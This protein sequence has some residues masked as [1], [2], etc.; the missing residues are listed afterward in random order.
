MGPEEPKRYW[1]GPE[2][3]GQ[4]APASNDEFPQPLDPVRG[5]FGRRDFL[6]AAGFTFVAAASLAGCSRAPV[7]KAIPFLVQPEEILPG[8]SYF[9][10]STCAGCTAGC[11]TLVKTRDGRPIK[12]EGNPE[13]AFSRGGLCAVGQASLLEL[14]DSQRLQGPMKNGKPTSWEEVDRSIREQLRSIR[15]S[16]VPVRFL[17]GSITSLT[18]REHLDRFLAQFSDAQRIAY[19]SLSASAILDAHEQTHGVRALP[20][21]RFDHAEVIVGFDADFLGTWISPVEFT[22]AYC[23]GRNLEANPPR[24]SY[25]AQFESRMSLT[26]SKA[27]RRIRVS[28]GELS[29]TVESLMERIAKLGHET[30][31]PGIP[32]MPGVSSELLEELAQ[33]LWQARGHSLVVCGSQD[34]RVQVL[35]NY[36]NHLLGNY[37]A[38][39]DL[40]HPSRQREGNDRELESLLK[41]IV[42]GR[43]AALFLYGVNP[44]YDLPGGKE[45]ADALKAVPLVVSFAERIDETARHAHFVCPEPHFLESWGDAGA[46]PGVISVFQPALN[47]LGNTRTAVESI[48]TWMGES[49]PAYEI[50]RTHWEA[51]IFLRQS[52]ERTFQEFWDH[53]VERGFAEVEPDRITPKPFRVDAVQPLPSSQP[54]ASGALTLVLYPKVSMLDGRHGHNAWLQELPDPISK[55]AWDNYASLSPAAANRLGV[56][57]GDVVRLELA[58]HGNALEL[59]AHVQPG[60]HDEIIAVALGYGRAGTGRFAKAGPQWLF[61][62]SG[63]GENGLV[64]VNA[65]PMLASADGALSYAGRVV[66]ISKTGRQHPLGCTQ[67]HHSLTTP[68]NIP[69]VGGKRR[70]IVEETTFPV[71]VAKNSNAKNEAPKDKEMEELWPADHPYTGHRWAMAIDMTACTGCSACV[72]ACQAENNIPTVGRD[73]VRRQREMH[74]LRIDRYYSGTDDVDVVHQPMMCQQCDHAPCETVCPVLATVHSAEGLNQ[75]IYNRCVGTRYCANNCPYKTRR[76]NW[77][78]YGRDDRLQNLALNPDVTVRTRGIMEK[79]TFCVQRIQ[80]AKIEANRRGEPVADGAIQTAC[81]QSCPAQ[82]IVFGDWNNPK[83]RIAELGRNPRRYRVLGEFNFQPAV[84]YLSVVRNREFAKKERKNG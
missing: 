21:F 2:E 20:H 82:A 72:I 29:R 39:I 74:W 65:A 83:S 5:E 57:Q 24:F 79:C 23:A 17:T 69:L 73:E 51:K 22:A 34:V 59:P 62:R 44:A 78:D 54:L 33:R 61:G 58:D 80:E 28:P 30:R 67:M 71:F 4:D 47:P 35:V 52:R 48:A 70:E 56:S 50:I 31:R 38:T 46:V 68:E 6:K 43:V 40:D 45:F 10:A 32:G 53:A 55:V 13:H 66:R 49:K 64:G 63:V 36:I 76:F 77:F 11:G 42:S 75:Q 8:R 27:D 19:D 81:Q 60:Q 25:H 1:R 12:L 7:E 41:E 3:T 16:H 15:A 26:G 9:Y 84:N 18:L 14:Y 37:G